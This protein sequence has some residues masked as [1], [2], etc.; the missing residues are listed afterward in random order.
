VNDL[1]A[2]GALPDPSP[3]GW[4]ID[5][6]GAMRPDAIHR[7]EEVSNELYA[8]GARELFVVVISSTAGVGDV[9]KRAAQKLWTKHPKAAVIAIN[10][11]GP[12]AATILPADLV[13]DPRALELC[14][15]V[16]AMAERAPEW[17]A[18]QQATIEL[19]PV[20]LAGWPSRPT[21]EVVGELA[22]RHRTPLMG[23]GAVLLLGGGFWGRRWNRYRSRNCSDCHRPRQLLGVGREDAHLSEGQKMEQSVGS[24]DYDVW[25]CGACRSVL[26]LDNTAWFSGYGRCNSCGHRTAKSTTTTLEYATEWSGGR[27]R[28]DS[29][30]AGCGHTSSYTRTTARLSSSSSSDWS[31][32]SGSSSSGSSFGGG[33]S[34]GGGSSGSW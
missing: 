32:S 11:L 5:L 21:E 12:S 18:V 33:S 22:T 30:C 2:T 9:G 1:L 6:T 8:S 25:W 10:L 29:T 31:S 24:V 23:F 19:R 17:T 26:I 3:R 15:R 27:E 20:L 7:L 28:I 13:G 16:D 4:V 14:N 34:S